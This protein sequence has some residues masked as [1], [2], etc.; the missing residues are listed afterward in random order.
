M[1]DLMAK[2]KGQSSLLLNIGGANPLASFGAISH[3]MNDGV[4]RIDMD[5][6]PANKTNEHSF[7]VNVTPDQFRTDYYKPFTDRKGSR[8]KTV[9]DR[10]VR[11]T[12]LGDLDVTIG[13]DEGVLIPRGA[14]RR[15]HR[16][17]YEDGREFLGRDGVYVSLGTN[18]S[19]EN[20]K[21]TPAARG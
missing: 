4:L 19:E 9:G 10:R 16:T 11:T 7:K 18:W 3:F 8:V 6:P 2:A 20:M 13:L 14:V 1:I 15:N 12:N 17:Q 21:K 5:D